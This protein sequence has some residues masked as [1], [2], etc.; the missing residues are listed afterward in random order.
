MFMSFCKVATEANSS[1]N[2]L[3]VV[4]FSDGQTGHVC[5]HNKIKAELEETCGILYINGGLDQELCHLDSLK[6]CLIY[7]ESDIMTSHL[8]CYLGLSDLI[9]ASYI[10]TLGSRAVR[11][12]LP[13]PPPTL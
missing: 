7:C 9:L 11:G 3:S 8:L 1:C 4:E 5:C 2:R 12:E 6:I 13:P 10:R